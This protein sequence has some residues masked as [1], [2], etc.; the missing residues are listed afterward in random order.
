MISEQART[1]MGDVL[2]L[3]SDTVLDGAN[4]YSMLFQPY[5]QQVAYAIR[6]FL[7]EIE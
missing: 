3:R 2:D 6:E 4:H 7:R 1:V 5:S